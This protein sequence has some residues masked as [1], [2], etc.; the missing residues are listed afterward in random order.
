MHLQGDLQLVFDALY[1]MGIIDP[2][3]KMDWEQIT[4]KRKDHE[5]EFRRA[6]RTVNECGGDVNVMVS[7]LKKFDSQTLEILAME[8]AKEYADFHARR[9]VQ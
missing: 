1:Q 5:F 4:L 9:S 3:L 8:V 6:V 7:E 2:V